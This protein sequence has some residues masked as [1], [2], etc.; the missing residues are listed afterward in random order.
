MKKLAR[1]ILAISISLSGLVT[2]SAAQSVSSLLQGATTQ[3][4]AVGSTDQ[5]GRDTPSGAVFGFLQVA[6][7]GNYK[8]AADYLQMSAVR[9][10]SQGPE[11]AEKLKKLMDSS[12]VGS[13]RQ[14]SKN[15]EGSSEFGTLDQQTIGV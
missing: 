8:A 9:R 4:P 5:L 15:R 1:L 14:L 12:F 7:A 2:Q 6:Q 11:V 3:A 10:P 13:P